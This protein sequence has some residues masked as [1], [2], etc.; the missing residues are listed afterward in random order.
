MNKLIIK[1][2]SDLN[3]KRE[4]GVETLEELKDVLI[5][6]GNMNNPPKNE[7]EEDYGHEYIIHFQKD[8]IIVA[9]LYDDYI[10]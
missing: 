1:L 9:K 4:Y 6:E 5:D 3:Y 8:G 10:E 7:I 2:A